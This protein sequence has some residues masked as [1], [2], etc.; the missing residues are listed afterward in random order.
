MTFITVVETEWHNNCNK[1]SGLF[2]FL[3]FLFIL[4]GLL[5]LWRCEAD[6]TIPP[7][8]WLCLSELVWMLTVPLDARSFNAVSFDVARSG[9]SLCLSLI[10][11]STVADLAPWHCL[12]AAN[13]EKLISDAPWR[14]VR[15]D[16][17][18]FVCLSECS[19]HGV[20]L[21]Q[22]DDGASGTPAARTL[23]TAFSRL[24]S[25]R[26]FVVL[27]TCRPRD[28]GATTDF[29]VSIQHNTAT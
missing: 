15:R 5:S 13:D 2:L 4:T 22:R 20:L 1:P 18:F 10:P 25:T 3:F 17:A 12:D 27:N 19:V 16:E 29:T 6:I 7:L 28:P 21:A 8:Q 26:R 14:P 23:Y 11:A 24:S 9:L